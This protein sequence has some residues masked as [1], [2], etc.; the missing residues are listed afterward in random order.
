MIINYKSR[1]PNLNSSPGGTRHKG[2]NS[3]FDGS[4]ETKQHKLSL[5]LIRPLD[6]LHDLTQNLSLNHKATSALD[7]L[8]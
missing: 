6:Y 5:Y 8:F 4:T 3:P 7:L 2:S 1:F